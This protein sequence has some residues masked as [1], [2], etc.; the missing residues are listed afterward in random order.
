MLGYAWIRTST[1]TDEGL[2]WP[3][4]RRGRTMRSTMKPAQCR[5][6]PPAVDRICEAT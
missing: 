5:I 2:K 6:Q 1:K 4:S 3:Q